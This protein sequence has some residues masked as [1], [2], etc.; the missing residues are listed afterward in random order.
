L[1]CKCSGIVLIAVIIESCSCEVVQATDSA[2]D[3]DR[4]TVRP[5]GSA[6]GYGMVS[7]EDDGVDVGRLDELSN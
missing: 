7:R 5:G 6:H 1:D 3:L 4:E 2:T